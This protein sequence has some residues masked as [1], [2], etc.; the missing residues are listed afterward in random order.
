MS[1][2]RER[3]AKFVVGVW[4]DSVI[5]DKAAAVGN[6]TGLLDNAA[7][8]EKH[9]CVADSVENGLGDSKSDVN[10]DEQGVVRCVAVA[11]KRLALYGTLR[12]CSQHEILFPEFDLQ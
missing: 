5:S 9:N 10:V 7:E 4:S 2:C 12:C 6:T 3:L 8:H 11:C 1:G